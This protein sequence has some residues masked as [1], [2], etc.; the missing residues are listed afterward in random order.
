MVPFL[1]YKR[2]CILNAKKQDIAIAYI[3]SAY[4]HPHHHSH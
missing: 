4:L 2:A 3:H 1:S